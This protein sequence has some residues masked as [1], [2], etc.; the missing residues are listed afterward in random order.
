M[1]SILIDNYKQFT[2]DIEEK[3]KSVSK[4]ISLLNEKVASARDKYVV[5]KLDEEDYKEIKK[6][7]KLQIE[8]LE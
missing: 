5:D 7:T 2:S 8:Q 1:Q 3:R 4:E 6:V